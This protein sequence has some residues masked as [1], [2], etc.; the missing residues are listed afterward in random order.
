VADALKTRLI[1]RSPDWLLGVVFRLGCRVSPALARRSP[2]VM[3]RA[4]REVPVRPAPAGYAAVSIDGPA[5]PAGWI[6]TLRS[7]GI[8]VS[9]KTWTDDLVDPLTRVTAVTFDG[10]IVGTASLAPLG[11]GTPR[12]GLVTWVG[13]RREHQGRGLGGPL[14]AACLAHAAA[15]GLSPVL[16]VTDDHRTAAIRTYLGM[17]FQ[18]CLNSWDW[19]HRPRWQRVRS[20]LGLPAPACG[21][22]SHA[23]PVRLLV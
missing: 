11:K 18:P 22:A 5:A 1:R 9:A 16:L 14:V 6:E 21:D 3:C 4:S 20:A 15:S 17:G 7:A 2:L 23:G 10:T 8:E 19:T 12:A 13:V